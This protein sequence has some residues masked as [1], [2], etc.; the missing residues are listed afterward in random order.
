M[1]IS[2]SWSR[3]RKMVIWKKMTRMAM[4]KKRKKLIKEIRKK[5]LSKKS[6]DNSSRV[7]MLEDKCLYRVGMAVEQL[8][9]RFSRLRI[10]TIRT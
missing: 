6:I 10:S 3:L 2:K 1:D 8:E 7:L 5:K 9:H 4:A